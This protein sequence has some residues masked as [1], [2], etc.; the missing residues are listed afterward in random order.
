VK[1]IVL[2]R[3][4][5]RLREQLRQIVSRPPAGIDRLSAAEQRQLRGLLRRMMQDD[6]AE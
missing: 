1:R 4:G 3:E 2:T 6:S 5:A